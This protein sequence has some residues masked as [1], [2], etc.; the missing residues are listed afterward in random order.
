MANNKSA[1]KRILISK[2]NRLQNRFYKS[3]IRTLTKM[4]LNDLE[5]YK[6][7]K[8]PSHKLKAK[9]RLDLVY[10]LIDKSYKKKVFYKNTA[11]RKKSKLAS[12]LKII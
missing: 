11:A 1:R 6:N 9:Q 2:R 4:F 10:S 12:Y 8:N 3:S 5:V 7:S